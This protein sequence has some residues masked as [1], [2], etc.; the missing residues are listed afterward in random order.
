MKFRKKRYR[1]RPHQPYNQELHTQCCKLMC[2]AENDT[3]RAM[4]ADAYSIGVSPYV[5]TPKRGVKP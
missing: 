5:P 1:S 3:Q 4:I 2:E